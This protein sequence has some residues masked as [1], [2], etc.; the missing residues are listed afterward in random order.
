MLLL[1]VCVRDAD[2][3]LRT[4]IHAHTYGI[5]AQVKYS[6]TKSVQLHRDTKT[7]R[8]IDRQMHTYMDTQVYT[9]TGHRYTGTQVHRYTGIHI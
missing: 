9:C 3:A 4:G 5:Q 6:D 1:V 2:T 7:H 8:I